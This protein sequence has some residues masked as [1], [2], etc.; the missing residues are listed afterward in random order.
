MAE[1]IQTSTRGLYCA[2]GDFYIDPWRAVDRAVITHAHADHA[3]AGSARYLCSQEGAAVLQHRLG[4]AA[5][6]EAVPYGQPV[7][8]GAVTVSLHPAGHIRGSAQVRVEHRGEVWVITG[9]YKRAA[10]PTCTAF[11]P[12]RCHTLV[13]ES[14]FGLPVYRWPDQRRVWPELQQ[15]WDRNA[16]TGRHSVLFTYSLG[17]AQRVLASLPAVTSPIVCHGAVAAMNHVYRDDGV[18][19]P[20]FQTVSETGRSKLPT[21][22]LVIAPPAAQ[23]SLW[24]RRFGDAATAF[25]SGWMLVRGSRRRQTVDRGF[26]VSD[27]VDWDDLMLSIRES[28]A[29]RVLVTHGSSQVVA[30]WLTEQG[31]QAAAL[32]TWFE[33]ETEEART[34]SSDAAATEAAASDIEAIEA[35]THETAADE[36]QA[37]EPLGN[38]SEPND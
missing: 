1:L 4:A 13:T 17:K 25:A 11:E 18:R 22:C 14:T 12:V 29:E 21:G 28:S 20:E 36:P 31:L 8:I 3:R 5:V 10:D 26:V 27:H 15:W 30:R 7:K 2:S 9:D 35:A 6:I 38:A 34:V 23:G 16:A 32:N 33:G 19:L 37:A 24:L